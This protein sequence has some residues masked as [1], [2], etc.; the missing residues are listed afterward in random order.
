MDSALPKIVQFLREH[1]SFAI[2]SHQRPDGD[3]IGSSLALGCALKQLGKTISIYQIDPIPAT[4][5]SLPDSNLLEIK[6]RLKG[7]YD[8]LIILEC[9]GLERTGLKDLKGCHVI[10]IDHHPNTNM[11]GALNWVDDSA[12]AVAELVYEL[13]LAL[14]LVITPS[15]ATNL[16]AAILTDTGS[17]QFPNTTPKTFSI[18]ADL[19]SKGANPASIARF[20]YMNQPHSRL[21]L[22]V[23]V[24][25][26]LQIHPT[27]PIAW[28]TLTRDMLQRTGATPDLTEG[29]VNYPLSLNRVQIVAFLREQNSGET[30]VSLRSKN[31]ID[32]SEIARIWGGGGHKNAAGLTISATLLEA[33]KQVIKELDERISK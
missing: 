30:R 32:V 13:I 7:T 16:Y 9:N 31:N 17:F 1:Q 18:A 2:L 21:K 11:F 14:R 26:T 5:K 20:V 29:F 15:I 23:E 12:A 27:K 24:L 19:S 22:L 4:Y 6:S 33:K 25:G 3:S 8:S 28:I 10:N